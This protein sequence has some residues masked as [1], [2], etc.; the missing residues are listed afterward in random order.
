MKNKVLLTI[1]IPTY[2]RCDILGHTLSAYVSDEEFDERVEI[3]ISDNC[4]TDNT[5]QVV[6]DYCKK[7]SNILYHCNKENIL[8][9]NFTQ[10]MSLGSGEYIKLANDTAVPNKGTLKFMLEKIQE[11]LV[12]KK[13]IFFYQNTWK[14]KNESVTIDGLDEFVSTVSFFSGWVLNFS[15]WR[16][17]F[18][19]L[20]DKNKCALLHFVQV[21]WSL[22]LVQLDGSLKIYFDNFFA[23]TDPKKK[24]MYNIFNVHIINY[25]SIYNEYILGKQI[26]K[27]T[28]EKEKQNLFNYF[29]IGW[30]KNIF[31]TKIA[32]KSFSTK[33][34]I[35]VIFKFYWRY[36]YFYVGLSKII[37]FKI[38]H[39]LKKLKI[40][41]SSDKSYC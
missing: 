31:I 29:V 40:K 24:N 30:I 19:N 18:N 36:S 9:R 27:K 41:V 37:I 17:D 26:S 10:A 22:R 3:V 8:D 15:A 32:E 5:K 20:D 39:F 6:M 1:G 16:S 4:S 25:L 21:D 33:N 7:Y 23:V 28:I 35:Y 14:F 12:D 13:K 11:N 34:F 2:N 38:V